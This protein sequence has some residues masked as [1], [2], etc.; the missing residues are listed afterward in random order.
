MTRNIFTGK[1]NIETV[2]DYASRS[3][4]LWREND[5]TTERT[6]N[7]SLP[8]DMNDIMKNIKR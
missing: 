1:V 7:T 3:L 5:S 6:L 8:E 2:L 4:Y